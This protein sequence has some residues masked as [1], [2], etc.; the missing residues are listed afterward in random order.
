MAN[1]FKHFM[2]TAILGFAI[3]RSIQELRIRKKCKLLK[4]QEAEN[5]IKYDRMEVDISTL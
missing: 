1:N 5:K 4:K 3:G 2:G